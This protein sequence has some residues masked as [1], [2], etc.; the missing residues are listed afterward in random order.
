MNKFQNYVFVTTMVCL[1]VGLIITAIFLM[2]KKTNTTYPPVIDNCPDYWISSYYDVDIGN[3]VGGCNSTEYGC[4]PD[5]KTTKSDEDGSNCPKLIS[6]CS[7]TEFGCC[8]DLKT[9]KTDEAGSTCPVAKCYNVRSLGTTS[10][11]CPTKMDFTNYST[12]Q[13]QTWASGCNITWDGITNMAN[14]C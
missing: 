6:S 13:K 12:C 8:P 10:D 11:S 5:H 1:L 14:A 4:C 7:T 3:T 2:R 9:P